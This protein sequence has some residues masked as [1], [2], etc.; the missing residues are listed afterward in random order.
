MLEARSLIVSAFELV[1]LASAFNKPVEEIA[2][3]SASL[4][5][6]LELS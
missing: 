1:D 6:R 3:A 4:D 2:L 5:A